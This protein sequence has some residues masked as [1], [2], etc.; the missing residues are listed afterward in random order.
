ML[1]VPHLSNT[2]ALGRSILF[3]C[4]CRLRHQHFDFAEEEMLLDARLETA[5]GTAVLVVAIPLSILC[6]VN[7]WVTNGS[8]EQLLMVIMTVAGYMRLRGG[9]V[10]MWYVKNKLPK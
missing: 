5:E 8:S 9:L 3:K 1:F 6:E 2:K 10:K 7:H 4:C